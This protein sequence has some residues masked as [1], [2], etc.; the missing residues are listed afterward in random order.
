MAYEAYVSLY[1]TA[2]NKQSVSVAAVFAFNNGM[3]Q[4]EFVSNILH[5]NITKSAWYHAVFLYWKTLD[6]SDTLYDR[7]KAENQM[8]RQWKI[9][10]SCYQYVGPRVPDLPM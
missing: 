9:F 8:R 5:N 10:R 7:C 6:D 4:D 3:T 2:A 1:R